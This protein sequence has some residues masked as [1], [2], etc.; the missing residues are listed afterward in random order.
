MTHHPLPFRPLKRLTTDTPEGRLLCDLLAAR[1]AI[2]SPHTAFDSAAG[3]INQ[4]LAAGL[5]ADRYSPARVPARR[6]GWEPAARVAQRRGADRRP[7]SAL[8]VKQFL[9]V[10]QI[11]AVG[12]TSRIV[13]KVAVACGS[14]GEFLCRPAQPGCQLLVTGEVRFHTCLEAEATAWGCWWPAILP[15]S[16]LPSKLWPESWRGN[17]LVA[18]WASRQE[19]DPLR[20]LLKTRRPPDPADKRS[21]SVQTTCP[22]AKSGRLR[23]RQPLACDF[24]MTCSAG[25]MARPV[26]DACPSRRAERFSPAKARSWPPK[27]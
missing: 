1:I 11:Q 9:R 22:C 25:L 8:R 6:S 21:A 16:A 14:A 18:V 24:R 7:D 17:S 2:Y 26:G 15:A 4:R 19:R 23:V 13:A 12:E 5:G 27:F 10:G 3:G 20:W